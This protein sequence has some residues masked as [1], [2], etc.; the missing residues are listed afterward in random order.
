LVMAEASTL[1]R[2]RAPRGN[3]RERTTAVSAT[4]L[5]G[6]LGITRQRVYEL[7]DAERVIERLPGGRFDQ[8]A[9]RL[10]YIKWLRD[11]ARRVARTSPR[12]DADTAHLAVKTEMLKLRLLEKRRLVPR[13]EFDALIDGIAGLVLTKLHG[14]PARVGGHDLAARRR[15]ELVVIELRRELSEAASKMADQAGEASG[16]GASQMRPQKPRAGA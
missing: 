10:A 6:H 12:S 3:G 9:C 7:A 1:D 11:A 15:A 4:Q 14:L 13:D 5:G 16:N 2:T 8:D